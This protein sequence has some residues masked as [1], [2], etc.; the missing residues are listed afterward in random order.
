V[1]SH[2]ADLRSITFPRSAKP[3][4]AVV[5][6]PILMVFAE[7]STEASCALAYLRWQMADGTV[8]C[9]ILAG[10]TR[11]AAKCK[12]SIPRMELMGALLAVRNARKILDSLYLELEAVRYFTDLSA[13]LCMLSMDSATF[14]EF[15]GMQVSKIKIKSDTEK[16]CFWISGELNLADM[17]IWP[18]VLLKDM[19]EG[20]PYQAGLLWMRD[21][22]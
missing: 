21:P 4:E 10:K 9:H 8:Q 20:T 7:G 19:A 13:V 16:E 12:I 5:G 18:T 22:P 6:K 15:V 14:L 1:V 2:L 3:K 17:S 11:V